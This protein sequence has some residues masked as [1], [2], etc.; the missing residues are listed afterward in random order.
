MV[1]FAKDIVEKDFI[2][3][4]KETSVL[5]AAKLMKERRHG[6]VLT[7]TKTDPEGIVTE[8][9][10][11]DKVVANGSDPAK[12]KLADIMTRRIIT[13]DSEEGIGEVAKVM[14]AQGVRRM[15]VTS[16]GAIVGVITSKTVLAAFEDYVDNISAQISRL[17]APWF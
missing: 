6:F 12:V 14:A 9:D 5:D 13:I 15:V 2:V 10:V 11:L 1:L 3:L 7:G 17:Q 8:W 16:K 4:S